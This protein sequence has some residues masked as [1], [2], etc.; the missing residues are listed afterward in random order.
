[1]RPKSIILLLLGAFFFSFSEGISRPLLKSGT[2]NGILVSKGEFW[3][4]VKDDNGYAERYLAP[5]NGPGPSRG[6]GFDPTSLRRFKEL[7]VGNRV[8]MKWSWDGH[9]RAL[10]IEIIKPSKESGMF[11]GYLLEIGDRWIDV[12]NT[13]EK[14]PWRFYLP[15]VGGYPQNGG[16]FDQSVI[17]PL[18]EHQPTNP[19]LFEW[20][21]QLRPRIVKLV[22]REEISFKP[23]YELDEVPPWLGPPGG[24]KNMFE[25][26]PVNPFDILEGKSVN[27]FDTVAPAGKGMNPFDSIGGQPATVN[28][29]DS[30]PAGGGATLNPFDQTTQP[31]TNPFD[32]A[33]PTQNPFEQSSSGSKSSTVNPFDSTEAPSKQFNPFEG[34]GPSS[35]PFDSVN[36]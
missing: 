22:T 2:L 18:R 21:Y 32:S 33:P 4:E 30:A 16:G 25:P 20:N 5:W 23:F 10:E 15:W 34:K 12:Q 14:I 31:T 1:M 13:D 3:I 26:K 24:I 27:P 35:N 6:G 8:S 36:P 28:P 17:E 11:E 29:F 19:I 9:L 7:V